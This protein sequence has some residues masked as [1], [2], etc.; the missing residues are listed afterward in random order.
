MT[1]QIPEPPATPKPVPPKPPEPKKPEQKKLKGIGAADADVA[2]ENIEIF[3]NLAF[4]ES[5]MIQ[6]HIRDLMRA[7]RKGLDVKTGDP[8]PRPIPVE[9]IPDEPITKPAAPK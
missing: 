9:E 3:A 2:Y 5:F 1:P 4:D 7:V 8:D 6:P